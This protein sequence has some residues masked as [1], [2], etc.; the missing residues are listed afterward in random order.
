MATPPLDASEKALVERIKLLFQ[1]LD[2]ARPRSHEYQSLTAEIHE[3][4]IAYGKLVDG[5]RGIE[6]PD[7]KER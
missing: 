4:S 6:P 5:R 1:G 7:S 3:L 2:D